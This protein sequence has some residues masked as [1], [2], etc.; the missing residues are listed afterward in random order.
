MPKLSDDVAKRVAQAESSGGV[1]DEC[2][3]PAILVDVVV[4][5]QKPGQK[6]DQWEW[7]Y[8]I[9]EDSPVYAGRKINDFVSTSEGSD[10]KMQAHFLAHG[11]GTDTDTDEL[12]NGRVM[13]H[14]IQQPK[15]NA[16]NVK[17]NKILSVMPTEDKSGDAP[18][19]EGSKKKL[20]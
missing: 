4:H 10:F 5:P 8:V 15:H 20:F 13:L 16:P 2:L 19:A 18:K 9:A 3:V 1:M 11:V 7:K 6:G 17:Q 14:I 12:L